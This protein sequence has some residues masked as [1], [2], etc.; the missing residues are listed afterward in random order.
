MITEE[1][2][3][4]QQCWMTHLLILV[5]QFAPR[6]V[7]YFILKITVTFIY[8]IF[9]KVDTVA[10]LVS[11]FLFFWTFF[12]LS[13]WFNEWVKTLSE[14][15]YFSFCPKSCGTICW[16][17]IFLCHHSSPA[18]PAAALAAPQR[19]SV[20]TAGAAVAAALV[21]PLYEGVLLMA[22][23]SKGK[24]MKAS[25]MGF[26]STKRTHSRVKEIIFE[27]K[28]TYMYTNICSNKI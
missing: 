10:S 24:R 17:I 6:R 18:A 25:I 2:D 3:R 22:T 28:W 11:I 27:A 26:S 19:P 12:S 16:G 7:I 1:V 21:A 14:Y 8:G 13:S 20:S 5:I 9:K 4:Y 23:I 15:T